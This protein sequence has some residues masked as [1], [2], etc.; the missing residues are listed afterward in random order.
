MYLHL[1]TSRAGRF[2]GAAGDRLHVL[3]FFRAPNHVGDAYIMLRY[4]SL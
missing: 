1:C 3:S 4:M 2:P